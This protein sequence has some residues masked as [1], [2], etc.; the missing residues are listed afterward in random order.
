MRDIDTLEVLAIAKALKLAPIN[1]NVIIKSDSNVAL[2]SFMR[3]TS[4][5][6]EIRN[7]I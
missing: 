5:N 1:S 6:P 3:G 4:T 2:Y 7:I